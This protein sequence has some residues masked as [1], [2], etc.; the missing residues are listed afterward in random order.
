MA[1]GFRVYEIFQGTSTT[2]STETTLLGIGSAGDP[3]AK[4]RLIHPDTA[5]LPPIVY[6]TNPDRTTNLDNEVLVAPL[7][8]VD[9]TL[10]STRVT[11]FE[12]KLEDRIVRETWLADQAKAAMPTAL[13]R[14]LYEYLVNPPA[15][16]PLNPV[17]IQWEPRDKVVN[18]DGTPR[19]FNVELVGLTVGQGETGQEFDLVDVRSRGGDIFRAGFDGLEAEPTG[20]VDRTV[21][22]TFLVVSEV[23]A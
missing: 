21:T 22:L 9:R 13:F 5:N 15:F 17:F 8:S 7:V 20:V 18:S 10:D 23:T 1:T 3:A 12:T 11:R 6:N 14:K 2:V 4:R 16:D 19:A